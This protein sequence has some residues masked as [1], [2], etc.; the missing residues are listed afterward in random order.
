MTPSFWNVIREIR[1]WL[2][3]AMNEL[4]HIDRDAVLLRFFAGKELR[5]EEDMVRLNDCESL[6]WL[7]LGTDEMQIEIVLN[8]APQ[9]DHPSR[10]IRHRSESNEGSSGTFGLGDSNRVPVRWRHLLTPEVL[11]RP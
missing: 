5:S 6:D 7:P 9:N 3:E 1:P 8:E 10:T 2:D 4:N 11:G